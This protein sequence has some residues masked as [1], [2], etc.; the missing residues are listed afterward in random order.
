MPKHLESLEAAHTINRKETLYSQSLATNS[1]LH[2][3]S[4]PHFLCGF[5]YIFH[6][7][8]FIF[9]EC[10]VIAAQDEMTI[11]K[12][13]LVGSLKFPIFVIVSMHACASIH[14]FLVFINY[15]V[16]ILICDIFKPVS[17]LFCDFVEKEIAVEVMLR[18]LSHRHWVGLRNDSWLTL[19]PTPA[20]NSLT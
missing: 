15:W 2:N 9:R 11:R 14:Y 16:V 10:A 8:E 17:Q 1:I 13:I 5:K 7:L 6:L 12:N 3:N 20:I 4:F 18:Y 19:M